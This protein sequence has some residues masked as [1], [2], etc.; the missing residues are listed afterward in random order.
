MTKARMDGLYLVGL[1]VA[2]FLLLGFALENAV[3][4]TTVDFKVVYYSARCLI[5]HGDPY[6][7]SALEH[8][9]QTE[10]GEIS[11][12]TAA[13]RRSERNYN[14]FPTAF[15]ITVPF[16]LLPFGPAHLL[17]LA[18]TAASFILACLLM[19]EIAAGDAPIFAGV[20]V[21]LTLAN[22]ELFLILGNP[23]GIAV[24]LCVVAAWC[25]VRDRFVAAGI[26]CM[27]VS[28]MLKPHD[29]G[30]VWLYFLLAGGANRKRALQTLVVVIVLSVPAMIWLTSVAPNWM[31]ELHSILT[32]YSSHGDVNDPGPASMASHG[33]GMVVSLQAVFS[34]FRD[35]P[36]FYNPVTYLICGGLLAAWLLRTVRTTFSQRAAWFA[37]APVA[38][39][40]MLPVY[41][42]IYDARLLLLTIPACVALWSRGGK[43]AWVAAAITAAQIVLTGGIFW[44][45]FFRVLPHLSFNNARF[46]GQVLIGVQAFPV[47][48]IL[49]LTAVFNLWIY[50]WRAAIPEPGASIQR[51]EKPG[52]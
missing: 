47:P 25:F 33:I 18:F 34:V 14:Y 23:A 16:A 46:G 48:L 6:Q 7:Q 32:A 21:G 38:A 50:L 2:V 42:R 12:E 22:S 35:D 4:V 15:P 5:E 29:A 9:Y 24:S 20:L 8:V 1:G 31:P 13:N 10:G 26:L 43:I 11:L 3:P 44:A 45:I 39:L 40:S 19:W 28:L 30:L 51:R 49:L 27:A 52:G 17:W 41:H 36:R 37:L